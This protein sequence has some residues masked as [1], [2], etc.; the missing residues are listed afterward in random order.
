[1]VYF[2]DEML[3]DFNMNHKWQICSDHRHQSQAS[4]SEESNQFMLILNYFSVNNGIRRKLYTLWI[5]VY[6]CW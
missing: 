2:T 4:L 1:M 3:R 6:F 5:S